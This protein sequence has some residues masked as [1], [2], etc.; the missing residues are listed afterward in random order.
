MTNS[1]PSSVPLMDR[2]EHSGGTFSVSDSTAVVE[3]IRETVSGAARRAFGTSVRAVVLTGSLSRNE[4]SI[5]RNGHGLWNVQGDAEFLILL[6]SEC[7]LPGPRDVEA[8][9]IQTEAQLIQQSIEC[10]LSLSYC[11][12]DF[13]RTMTPHMFAYETRV[14][15]KVVSGEL[16]ALSL[17]P[18]FTPAD[19]PVEDAWRTLTNRMIELA[20]A[21]AAHKVLSRTRV[22]DS[23]AYRTM[24]LT[25]DTATSLLLFHGQYAPTYQQRAANFSR[26][27]DSPSTFPDLGVSP[28][29]FAHALAWCT[30]WKLSGEEPAGLVTWEWVRATCG[31]ALAVWIW[32]LQQLTGSGD[33]NSIS[34][35]V[36]SAADKQPVSARV[37]GWLYVVRC[38]GWL[39]SIAYWPHWMVMGF[40][41]T[42]RYWIYEASGHLFAR[43]NEYVAGDRTI[44][45]LT[46]HGKSS[47]SDLPL[48]LS[49]SKA[50]AADWRTFARSVAWNYHRYL[51]GTRA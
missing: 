48:W 2:P 7:A 25:L 32:E 5:Q 47:E 50:D 24:K 26:F 37:R 42:P 15:G 35:L 3:Q 14:S 34:S 20:E 18:S 43:L 38:E 41:A 28:Q 22:P 11:H 46:E 16:D 33:V 31:R 10:S 40:R 44:P 45:S 8:T 36:T 30:E 19:I 39:R 1:S 9:V 23:I 12:E 4:G 17:I 6:A 13:F 51:E 29:E 49:G 21:M 27:I